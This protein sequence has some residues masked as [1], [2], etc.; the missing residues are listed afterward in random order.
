MILSMDYLPYLILLLIA[1]IYLQIHF[2]MDL[3]KIK[4]QIEWDAGTASKRFLWLMNERIPDLETDFLAY[5]G[6]NGKSLVKI[7]GEF[8][9]HRA[10][11]AD[12][13]IIM[14]KRHMLAFADVVEKL[15][16][17]K[18]QSGAEFI[19]LAG[20]LAELSERLIR[21]EQEANKKPM[22]TLARAM[23]RKRNGKK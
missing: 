6:D 14:E 22:K 16:I 3:K 10:F 13:M 17:E 19:H 23:Q 7:T 12:E 9:H 18:D 20:G 15:K 21:L 1:I 11:I 2:Q 8:A 5:C 4:D